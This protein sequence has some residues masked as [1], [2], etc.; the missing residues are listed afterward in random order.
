MCVEEDFR[1]PKFVNVKRP[2]PRHTL[3]KIAK[4]NDKEFILRAARH[5]KITYNGS[6]IRLLAD[7]STE[8]LQARRHWNDIFETLKDKNLQPRIL[9]SAKISYG[10][11]GEIKSVADNKSL[12][13]S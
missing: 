10:Y 3:V 12:G 1:S 6:P 9:Y 13:T 4:M 11:E 7:S 8:T 5:K 2:T